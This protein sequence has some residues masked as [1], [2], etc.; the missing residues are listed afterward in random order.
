M[1][2]TMS[3]SSAKVVLR[4]ACGVRDGIPPEP[5]WHG[6][7]G[8]NATSWAHQFVDDCDL[9][10]LQAFDCAQHLKPGFHYAS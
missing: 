3:L 7:Q 2:L 10:A 6:D 4:T 8:R 5:T 1:R 9:T